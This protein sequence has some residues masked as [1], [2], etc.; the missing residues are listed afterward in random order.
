MFTLEKSF[1]FSAGHQLSQHQGN[2]ARKHGHTYELTL[3]LCTPDLQ[4]AGPQVNMVIDFADIETI[5][6][7]LL[8]NSLDHHWLNDTLN[9]ESPTMEFIARWI[10]QQAKERLPYLVSVTLAIPQQRV[11]YAPV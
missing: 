8:E 5:M 3:K 1:V 11:T 7:D 10:Y 2:C 6:H 9:T 4:K